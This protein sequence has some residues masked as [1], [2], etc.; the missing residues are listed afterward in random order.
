MLFSL[1]YWLI[2]LPKCLLFVIIHCIFNYFHFFIRFYI[3][4]IFRQLINFIT[5]FIT[6]NYLIILFRNFTS[7][8]YYTSTIYVVNFLTQLL[9]VNYLTF[10]VQFNQL[11][12]NFQKFIFSFANQNRK[13]IVL[14]D[15]N[16]VNKKFVYFSFIYRY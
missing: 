6:I 8:N 1:L 14:F 3:Y 12:I 16:S 15:Q 10:F 5:L 7:S 9:A 13:L 2:A 4:D 11:I